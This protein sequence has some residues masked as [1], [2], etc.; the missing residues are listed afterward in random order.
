MN[1]IHTAPSDPLTLLATEDKG[2]GILHLEKGRVV[3]YQGD[4]ADSVYYIQRGRVEL[5]VV[6]PEGKHGVIGVLAVGDFFGEE[7]LR[8]DGFRIATAKALVPCLLM[9]I[10]KAVMMRSLHNVPTFAEVFTSWLLSRN[11]RLQEDLADELLNS[12]EKRLARALLLLGG[13]SSEAKNAVVIPRVS[14]ETLAEMIGTSRQRV[15]FFMNKFRRLRL[16]EYDDYSGHRL[17]V[18][19]SLLGVLLD[20][21]SLKAT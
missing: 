17:L 5:T 4:P 13:I 21:Q 16:V 2:K 1:L 19:A 6:S 18:R 15:N 3:F 7:C 9:R 12:A 14:Q 20:N 8:R 10:A 11:I